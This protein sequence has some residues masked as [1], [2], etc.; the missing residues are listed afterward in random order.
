MFPNDRDF[1]SFSPPGFSFYTFSFPEEALSAACQRLG[2]R[3]VVDG[4]GRQDSLRRADPALIDE[5]RRLAYLTIRVYCPPDVS[6]TPSDPPLRYLSQRLCERLVVALQGSFI[7]SHRP[8]QRL[9]GIA[10]NRAL[11]VIESQIHTGLSVRELAQEAYLS[12]CTLEYAFRNQVGL[13][14]KK[15]INMQRLVHV[16]RD[17]RRASEHEAIAQIAN[18]W[19]IWHMGQFARD[20]RRLFGEL[21]SETL[22]RAMPVSVVSTSRPAT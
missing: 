2:L 1:R 8:S 17:L 6:G 10:I 14:P 16:R 9:R 12:R 15:F 18:R 3:D 7:V 20:Y 4:L 11:D 22:R 19:G 21:P 5:I 13:S